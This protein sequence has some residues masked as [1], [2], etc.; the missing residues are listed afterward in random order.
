M[1]I[2]KDTILLHTLQL[3]II[4]TNIHNQITIRHHTLN[5]I[6]IKLHT[7][8]VHTLQILIPIRAE[9]HVHQ[10]QCAQPDN[11]VVNGD[12]VEQVLYFN[13]RIRLLWKFIWL[14]ILSTINL[15]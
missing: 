9:V 12:I 6:A 14:I 7:L 2:T 4:R 8:K 3:I 1:D 10:T 5:Q 15:W 11:A 13:L